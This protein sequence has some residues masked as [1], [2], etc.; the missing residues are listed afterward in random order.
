MTRRKLLGWSALIL[1]FSMPI[2]LMRGVPS[3]AMMG[4][5]LVARGART[6]SSLTWIVTPEGPNA[7]VRATGHSW[8]N[9]LAIA[10]GR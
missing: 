6:C 4:A 1:A 9:L 8:G 3:W 5:A 2:V 10:W 7:D